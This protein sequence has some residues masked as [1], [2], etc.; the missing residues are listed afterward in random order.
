MMIEPP[1]NVPTISLIVVTFNSEI[2]FENLKKNV[3]QSFS[4][5]A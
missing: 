2:W 1:E 3:Y 5:A 4:L